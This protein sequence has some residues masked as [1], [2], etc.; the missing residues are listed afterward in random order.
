MYKRQ[1]Q[2]NGVS[3]EKV[4]GIGVGAPGLIEDGVVKDFAD[5]YKRQALSFLRTTKKIL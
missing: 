1:Q 5:V 4:L 3:T 2:K